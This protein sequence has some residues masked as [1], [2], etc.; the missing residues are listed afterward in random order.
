MWDTLTYFIKA[1][2]PVAEQ[3][4][5]R[6][7]LHPDDPPVSP[8]AGVARIFRSHEALRR[9]TETVP[10]DYN[11]LTFCQG[12]ISEMPENVLDAI[13]Y[14]GS[15]NKISYV[16]FRGVIPIRYDHA[17]NNNVRPEPVEGRPRRNTAPSNRSGITGPVP[18][19]TETFIDEGHV[20]MLEAMRAY[21]ESGFDGPMIDDH[22][23]DMVGDS[24]GQYHA[25][26]HALGYMKALMDVADRGT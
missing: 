10:S 20:D 8:V 24:D 1:V 26:A 7:A 14:F 3:A 22:V 25:H 12:A 15:R 2:V 19:F 11:G 4:G 13:R 5:V 9:L 17:M 6:M 23:P 16:H 21:K 18:K